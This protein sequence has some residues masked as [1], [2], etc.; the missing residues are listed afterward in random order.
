M[1][2]GLLTYGGEL[3]AIWAGLFVVVAMYQDG[4]KYFIIWLA[5]IILPV[6][7]ARMYN[8]PEAYLSALASIY[9]LFY[10]FTR[11]DKESRFFTLALYCT[12]ITCEMIGKSMN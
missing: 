3:M 4:I 9:L 6:Y 1:L 8:V 5:S 11:Y 10:F 12:G 2:K 7:I